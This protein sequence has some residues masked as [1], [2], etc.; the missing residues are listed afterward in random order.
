M[1]IN[2]WKLRA[3][4]LDAVM[5]LNVE[6]RQDDLGGLRRLKTRLYVRR[7]QGGMVKDSIFGKF[8]L[9]QVSRPKAEEA[10]EPIAYAGGHL[11]TLPPEVR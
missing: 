6:A 4:P 11:V 10:S 1:P 3:P 8:G 2:F 9:G 7:P 5:P